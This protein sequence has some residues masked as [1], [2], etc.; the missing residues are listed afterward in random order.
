MCG[1]YTKYIL[2][3][4]KKQLGGIIILLCSVFLCQAR[5]QQVISSTGSFDNGVSKSVSWT[6][7]EI[8]VET[9]QSDQIVLTQGFQQPSISV[10]KVE[11]DKKPNFKLK[12]YPNP[13]NK[14]FI[15][16]TFD[17]PEVNLN[18]YLYSTKGEM[19]KHFEL[20]SKITKL[21]LEDITSGIYIVNY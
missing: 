13:T 5:S 4:G 2:T 7:G 21:D 12:L 16:E 8:A 14:D 19:I 1:L 17:T 3:E 15:I 20:E 9:L 11:T 6:I 18:A 10:T